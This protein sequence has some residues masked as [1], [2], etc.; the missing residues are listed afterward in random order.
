M[1][2]MNTTL[3]PE[4]VTAATGGPNML[5]NV[6]AFLLFTVLWLAFVG[7]ILFNP[8]VLDGVW[9]GLRGLPWLVQG[10]VWLLLLPVVAGLWIWQ[11][12]WSLW[13][14]LPLVAGLAVANVVAFYP[15]RSQANQ[16]A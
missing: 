10:L 14:R 15:W 1:H 16:Q 13:L 4:P 6:V 7:A 5:I 9:D 2:E 8:G 11:T 12:D 3:M